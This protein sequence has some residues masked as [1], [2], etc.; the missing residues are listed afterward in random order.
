MKPFISYCLVV[1]AAT[2]ILSAGDQPASAPGPPATVKN[3]W[4]FAKAWLHREIDAPS[5][6]GAQM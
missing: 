1:L 6:S 2:A 4:S 5:D 3:D